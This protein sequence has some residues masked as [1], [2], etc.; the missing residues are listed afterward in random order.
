MNP[1]IIGVAGPFQDIVYVLPEG[2]VTLG[3]DSSNQMWFADSSLS[4]R[5]CALIRNGARV[6]LRDTGSRNGT[7]VNGMPVEEQELHHGDQISIGASLLLFMHEDQGLSAPDDPDELIETTEFRGI[8]DLLGKGDPLLLRPD[9]Q[10]GT[11]ASPETPRDSRH[12]NA[13]LQFAT[14]IGRIRDRESLQWQ[15]LGFVFD[16]VPAERGAVLL[17]NP[18]GELSSAATWDRVRG[19]E[20]PVT[21]SPELVQ[22][23]IKGRRGLLV[24]DRTGDKE[25]LKTT[26]SSELNIHCLLCVPLVNSEK[27]LGAIYLDRVSAD[28]QFQDDHLQ[29]MIAVAD[30]AALAIENLNH[31]EQLAQEN[32]ALRAEMNLEH[33]MVGSSPAMRRVFELIRRVAPT[34]STVLIQGESGTGKELVARAIHRNS[35]RANAPFV[36]INCAAITESLL[37][38]ELFGHEKGSFTG[39]VAQKRGKVE[40]ADGGTLF[41]DEIG[42]LAMGLQAKLLR[43]LQEREFERVG[44][45]R[46]LPLDIRLIAASNKELSGAVEA[47]KFRP[48]LFYRLNVVCV[49]LPPLRERREDIEAMANHFVMKASR[50]TKASPKAF[51]PEALLCMTNYDWPGNV[52]EL[53]NAVERALVLG[54][55][56][57]IR[58]DDLPETILEAGGSGNDSA[59]FHGAIKDLKKQL[60][61]QALQEANGNYIEAAKTLGIHPNSMLRLIRNFGLKSITKTVGPTSHA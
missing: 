39:A 4:R 15:L 30:I 54:S 24:N 11:G 22:Q 42:E 50:K 61:M 14:A 33:D 53:E 3:R 23:V 16:V 27:A 45:T 12:L 13:L 55:G 38:S 44:G 6:L 60:I 20:H 17:V 19:P 35:S 48:D 59:G 57:T 10:A 26:E 34:D 18:S 36:A 1:R 32:Q 52:R 47:G 49:T 5:H 7:R 9:L 56:D 46:S 21:Y 8:S 58:A 40:V 51:S 29:L 25:L 43:V 2:E 41:L 37:E 28:I 31:W